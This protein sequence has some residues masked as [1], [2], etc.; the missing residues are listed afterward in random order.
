[1]TDYI[2]TNG[3]DSQVGGGGGDTFDY[4]QGGNDTVNGGGGVDYFNFGAAFHA[5]DQ[6]IGGSDFDILTLVGD[7]AK[8]VFTDA[9]MSQVERINLTGAH[10]YILTFA[11]GNANGDGGLQVSFD[12]ATSGR[13]NASRVHDFAVQF[14][15]EASG[16]LVLRGGD[17]SDNFQFANGMDRTLVIDGGGGTA[18]YVTSFG[19]SHIHFADHSFVNI[20]QLLVRGDTRLTFADGNVAAGAKLKIVDQSGAE[21]DNLID[22]HK[23]MDGHL[24]ISM[25]AGDDTVKGGHLSDMLVGS[26][27]SDRLTGGLGG[28]S[29]YGGAGADTFVYANAGDSTRA[30]FDIILDLDD[31]DHI[32]L[33]H[34]DADANTDGRQHLHRVAAFTGHVGEMTVS[35]DAVADRTIVRADTDGDG[36]GE[37]EL[38][39]VGDHAGFAGFLL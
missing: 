7:Y 8:T 33:S 26:L 31:S 9:M 11:N 24:D 19:T 25:G 27:G 22:G 5:G 36:K 21:F 4:S 18:N 20:Q 12:A 15:S 14:F 32:D 10:R 16:G 29:L 30:A 17:L 28:D 39:I 3:D 2:G 38:R 23:E 6:V 1:M 37:F 13:I 34:I 35:Y